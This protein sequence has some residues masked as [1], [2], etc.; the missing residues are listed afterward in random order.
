MGADSPQIY[1]YIYKAWL[2]ARDL[3]ILSSSKL[4][5][6]REGFFEA[7]QVRETPESNE[8]ARQLLWEP[9][10]WGAERENF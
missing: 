1:Q 3:N 5:N 7:V 4:K 2:L 9:Q 6:P 10:R 8:T